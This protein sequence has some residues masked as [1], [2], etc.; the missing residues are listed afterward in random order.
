MSNKIITVAHVGDFLRYP[1][2]I[3]L[4]EN[5]LSNGNRVR[6]VSSTLS[7][8][9]P[10][11]ISKFNTFSY[12]YVPFTTGSGIQGKFN[13]FIKE[14]K[15]FRDS[16]VSAMNGSQILW[17]T[18]DVTVKILGDIVLNYKHIMQLMELIERYPGA[19]NLKFLEFPIE[20]YARKAHKV[21]VPDLD[22]AYIQQAW[23]DLKEVP[24]VLPNKPY[25]IYDEKVE[26][27]SEETKALEKIKNEKRKVILYS[28]LITPERNIGDFAKAIRDRS[29][30]CIYV[31]GKNFS[32][33]GYL[34]KFIS[35]N[36]NVEYLGYFTAPKHLSFVKYAYVGLTPYVPT[37]SS[38]HPK[39][40]ALYCA[41]NKVYE[42][43]A[44][45]VP[46]L[47]TNV[48]G[49]LR[50]FE[51]YKIG[52][53]SKDMTKES[54]LQGLDYIDSHH[55]EMSKNAIKFFNKDDLDEIVRDIIEDK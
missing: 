53:C 45:G 4:L 30:Y 17:T 22:R 47:G 34:D 46:M 25:S 54:I 31:M 42:Y 12:Y 55:D 50:P 49:L 38:M 23:W 9:I 5:L 24:I 13:R 28:G 20:K 19:L 18:T 41:P 7:D 14:K 43:S 32:D 1:P 27:N 39:I 44:F 3:S 51:Q 37:K 2:V 21:V 52:K 8:A 40:N 48:L 33:G 6:L 11:R 10:E 36:P 16:V 29:D 26:L 15:S 35:D